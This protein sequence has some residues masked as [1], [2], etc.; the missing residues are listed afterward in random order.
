[1]R[2]RTVQQPAGFA[3]WHR[4]CKREDNM[5]FRPCLANRHP[6]DCQLE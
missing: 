5:V 6:I 3:T 4:K 2:Q 1:V